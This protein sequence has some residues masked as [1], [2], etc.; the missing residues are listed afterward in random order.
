MKIKKKPKVSIGLPVF[1][2]EKYLSKTIKSILNQ[3]Y[4]NIEL[5]ISDNASTDS[6]PMICADFKKKDNR[7][8]YYRNHRNFG[9]VENQNKVASLATSKYFKWTSSSDFIGHEFIQ[10]CV[11]VLEADHEVILCSTSTIFID[12]NDNI[13]RKVKEDY[14]LT[15]DE[16][17]ERYL[18]LFNASR[19]NNMYNGVLRNEILKKVHPEKKYLGADNVLMFELV[20]YG[21]FIQLPDHLFYRRM[22]TGTSGFSLSEEDLVNFLDPLLQKPLLFQKIKF[23]LGELNAFSS[24]N[25]DSKTKKRLFV[26]LLRQIYWS[27]STIVREMLQ[28]I[29]HYVASM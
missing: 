12:E 3:S 7:V 10:N 27:K 5:I 18:K 9:V 8:K 28:G 24:V 15:D 26:H 21:K 22:T 20:L 4:G 25:V 13:I 17:Y 16:P 19:L 29:K 23:L 1:N 2:S 14:N 11:K 6:T